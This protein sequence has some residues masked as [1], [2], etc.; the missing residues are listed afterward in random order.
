[1]N[2][3][4]ALRILAPSLLLQPSFALGSKPTTKK[5]W[6]GGD[7][8]AHKIFGVDWFYTW[9]HGGNDNPD[10]VFVPMFKNR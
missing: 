2:R 3:R 4:T 7:R 1:M 6:A 5:G 8:N 10:I 9:W